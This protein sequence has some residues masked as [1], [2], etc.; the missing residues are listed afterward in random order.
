MW[1]V[2]TSFHSATASPATS[3]ENKWQTC[4]TTLGKVGA[5]SCTLPGGRD[6]NLRE[7]WMMIVGD[8]SSNEVKEPSTKQREHHC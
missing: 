5:T 4:G 3:N 1:C 2:L 7:L 8:E 6:R